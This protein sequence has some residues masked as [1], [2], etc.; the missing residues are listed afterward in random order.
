MPIM[1]SLGRGFMKLVE[2]GAPLEDPKSYQFLDVQTA[3][4]PV[5]EQLMRELDQV[6][7]GIYE[8]PSG[9]GP[10][11]QPGQMEKSIGTDV[12]KYGRQERSQAGP[13]LG[14]GGPDMAMT[15]SLSELG[16]GNNFPTM[17]EM[18]QNVE[19]SGDRMGQMT[20]GPVP[21]GPMPN[22]FVTAEDGNIVPPS[23]D[24]EAQGM[25]PGGP[26]PGGYKRRTYGA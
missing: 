14:G 2:D 8:A 17:G 16:L 7:S 25:V 13:K 3:P 20:Q 5:R 23:F 11:I 24:E 12:V 4:P 15:P 22:P 6:R 10:V 9:K 1:I 19:M 21:M 18:A 26:T